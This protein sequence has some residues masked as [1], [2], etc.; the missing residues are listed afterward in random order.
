MSEPLDILFRL[1]YDVLKERIVRRILKRDA[2]A[3]IYH[4]DNARHT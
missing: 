3:T 2:S 4:E 1:D